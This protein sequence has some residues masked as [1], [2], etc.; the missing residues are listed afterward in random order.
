MAKNETEQERTD[1]EFRNHINGITQERINKIGEQVKES[2]VKAAEAVE[3]NRKRMQAREFGCCF[4]AS[5]G[6]GGLY[7]AQAAGLIAPVVAQPAAAFCYI[8]FGY[9]L[10]QMGKYGRRK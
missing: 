3:Q 8:Y 10:S 1:R 7:L 5:V 2:L 4:L 9:H 6:I